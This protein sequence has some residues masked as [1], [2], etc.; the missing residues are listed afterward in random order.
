MRKG[1]LGIKLNF[2]AV[3][4]FLLAIIGQWLPA[5]LV[6]AF[7]M[8]VEKD[9]WTTRQCMQAAF[10]GF[11]T[12]IAVAIEGFSAT[13]SSF[14]YSFSWTSANIG[15]IFDL[16]FSI[17]AWLVRI[18]VLVLGILGLAKAA[19]GQEANTP[20][21]ASYA[22]KAY[23]R[24]R[25]QYPAMQQPMYNPQYPGQPMQQPPMQ[26]PMP[27]QPPVQQPPMQPPVQQPPQNMGGMPQQP[28]GGNI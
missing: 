25:P 28:P 10:L 18:L 2:Y 24:M 23:G 17:L 15:N 14:F 1:V 26:Q 13:L 4:A 3:V 12:L 16:V 27:M 11:I 8:V 21:V 5:F 6:L 22:D 20:I 9:E 19:K 7:V